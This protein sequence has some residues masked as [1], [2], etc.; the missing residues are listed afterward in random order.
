MAPGTSVAEAHDLSDGIEGAVI[1]ELGSD[2]R[3]DTHIEPLAPTS[4]GE[5][6]TSAR[7]D[8]V[9]AVVKAA[10]EEPD[11]VDCHEVLVTTAG[12]ETSV[13]AHVHARRDLPLDRIHAASDRIEKRVHALMPEVGQVLI[14]FEPTA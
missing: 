10:L 14:H 11:V 9:D 4:F 12:A 3:V 2:V 8:V 5:D 1:G 13:V 6:T 7:R